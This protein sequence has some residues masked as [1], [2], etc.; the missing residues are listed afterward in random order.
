MA[1]FGFRKHLES[2]QKTK[3]TDADCCEDKVLSKYGHKMQAHL[4]ALQFNSSG[5]ND[6]CFNK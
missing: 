3:G 6:S 2:K 5:G 4:Q 1:R